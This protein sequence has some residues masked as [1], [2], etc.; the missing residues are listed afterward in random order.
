[1]E[2]YNKTYKET[3]PEYKIDHMF[4]LVDTLEKI[5]NA[6]EV[7]AE[8]DSEFKQIK[9]YLQE[10]KTEIDV[11]RSTL[12]HCKHSISENRSFHMKE[13]FD[14]YAESL[15]NRTVYKVGNDHIKD[16]K[17]MA[18]NTNYEIKTSRE[19]IIET[20]LGPGADIFSLGVVFYQPVIVFAN[21]IT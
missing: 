19:Y 15:A 8:T 9:P 7:I 20:G 18:K 14:H 6:A 21:W 17:K 1:M 11:G 4:K 2:N 13:M 3:Y 16:I 12:V 5:T 10:C